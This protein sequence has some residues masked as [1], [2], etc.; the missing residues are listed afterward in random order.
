MFFRKV[1]PIL[2]AGT[3]ATSFGLCMSDCPYNEKI[4][5]TYENKIRQHAPPEKIFETFASIKK[6]KEFFMTEKD[7]FH[8]LTPYNYATNIDQEEFFTEFGSRVFKII[9]VNGDGV[10]DFTEY[11]F[12]VVMLSLS[13][14]VARTLFNKVASDGKCTKKQF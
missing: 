10:L 11:F 7:F 13:N 1:A 4:R 12:F 8:S 14:N 3:M 9:D 6:G 2:A 5:G